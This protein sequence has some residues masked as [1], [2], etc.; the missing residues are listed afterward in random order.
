MNQDILD[1][2]KT[3]R[4]CVLAVE[5]MDGSPHAAT[6][7]FAHLDNPF[8]FFFETDKAYRKSEP[9][10]GK[11][12]TRASL[13]IGSNEADMKTFQMD[14]EARLIKDTEAELYEQI[15]H[16]K[17]PEKKGKSQGPNYVRFLFIPTWWRFTNWNTPKGKLILTSTDKS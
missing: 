1:Y 9:L 6:V 12:K 15:Y 7:H 5:M 13:V 8:M 2:I 10:F 17:F 4:V 11:D 16:G 3:Q 14:G